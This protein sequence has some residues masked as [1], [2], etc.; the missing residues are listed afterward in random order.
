MADEQFHEFQLDG[1]GL[2][3]LFMATTVVLVVV[4]LCG[5]MVGRGARTPRAVVQAEAAAPAD[6]PTVSFESEPT[7]TAPPLQDD[8]SA[9]PETLTYPD[10]LSAS[11]PPP[12]TLSEPVAPARVTEPPPPPPPQSDA[13]AAAPPAFTRASAGRGFEVQVMSVTRRAEADSVAKRLAAKKYPSFVSPAPDG[14]FRVRVGPY[15]DRKEAVS[16]ASRLEKEEKFTSPWLVPASAP[17]R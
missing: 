11:T 17:G 12:E 13:A 9:G 7:E 14:R 16:V 8:A 15:P 2:V 10:R 4:F 1:K 6:D 5:V 3:F